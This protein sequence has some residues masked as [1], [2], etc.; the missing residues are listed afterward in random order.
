MILYVSND[1]SLVKK[2]TTTIMTVSLPQIKW[3]YLFHR[4]IAGFWFGF[5]FSLYG[6]L[7]V[8]LCVCVGV[9]LFVCFFQLHISRHFWIQIDLMYWPIRIT[10]KVVLFA[11]GIPLPGRPKSLSLL[12]SLLAGS[13]DKHCTEQKT[14]IAL[15]LLK[16]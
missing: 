3:Q 12:L 1:I 9:F 15:K 10:H 14:H 11:F 6:L 16:D 4:H 2:V 8:F 5:F 13:T 7:G